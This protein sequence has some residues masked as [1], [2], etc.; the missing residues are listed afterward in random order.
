MGKQKRRESIENLGFIYYR[1]AIPNSDGN[2]G[3]RHD[4]VFMDTR[5][6]DLISEF[7]LHSLL[8]RVLNLWIRPIA[9]YCADNVLEKRSTDLEHYLRELLGK[10][11]AKIV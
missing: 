11:A 5:D 8:G 9:M 10:T 7:F 1:T 3:Y 2:I 4:L 6:I